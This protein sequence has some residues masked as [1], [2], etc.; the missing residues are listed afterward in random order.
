MLLARSSNFCSLFFGFC[1]L[2]I[3]LACVP[4]KSGAACVS[5][6]G[7]N[8][9]QD[10]TFNMTNSYWDG[11]C[12]DSSQC[13]VTT[14]GGK[15]A[16]EFGA[17][18]DTS[19]I[20]QTLSTCAL[21][22][23][24]LSFQLASGSGTPNEFI[25]S[26]NSQVLLDLVNC[27]SFS[28]TSHS[29]NVQCDEGNTTLTFSGQHDSSF[30]YLTA[31]SVVVG[32]CQSPSVSP[33]PSALPSQSA[34]PTPSVSVLPLPSRSPSLGLNNTNPMPSASPSQSPHAESQHNGGNMVSS[35]MLQA[36]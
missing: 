30:F 3:T 18:G 33:S 25:V 24:C 4:G 7:V 32:P 9:V 1:V 22:G 16:C 14:Y 36:K 10:G 20:Q 15:S 17:I 26:W 13:N 27:S 35:F 6:P 28:W 31:V 19:D 2:L 12:F 5:E 29:Y 8:L 34:A 23:Y 21:T 11:N